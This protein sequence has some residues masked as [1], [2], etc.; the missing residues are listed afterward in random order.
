MAAS[1]KARL[2]HS[3]Y[4]CHGDVIIPTYC[5]IKIPPYMARVIFALDSPFGRGGHPSSQAG[6]NFLI[7]IMAL[8]DKRKVPRGAP[9]RSPGK[10]RSPAIFTHPKR[11]FLS[12]FA[13]SMIPSTPQHLAAS[14]PRAATVRIGNKEAALTN[15]RDLPVAP[16][17]PGSLCFFSERVM[18]RFP[19]D[20]ASGRTSI[21]GIGGACAQ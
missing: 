6:Q 8:W 9:G 5:G 15:H 20:T 4:D 1:R 19:P 17:G 7:D 10:L 2:S 3:T 21:Q 11:K 16:A 18:C 12:H 13:V 14:Q